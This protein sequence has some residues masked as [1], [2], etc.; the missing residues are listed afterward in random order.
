MSVSKLKSGR[1]RAQVFNR[2]TGERPSKTFETKKEALLWEANWYATHKGEMIDFQ[3]A[4][5]KYVDARRNVLSPSTLRNYDSYV[6]YY[7]KFNTVPVDNITEYMLQTWVNSL[8]D[9]I[10]PKTV[11][12]VYAHALS[13]IR[14]ELP[15]F[16]PKVLLPTIYPSNLY[17]PSE[18]EIRALVDK[19]AGTPWEVPVALAMCGLR[20]GEICALEMKNVHDGYVYIERDMVRSKNEWVIKYPK[21]ATSVRRVPVP[22][23]VTDMIKEKGVVCEL[24]PNTISDKFPDLLE[25][26]GIHR[27]RFHDLRAYFASAQ[28]ALGIPELF[29]MR[30]GGWSNTQTMRKIYTRS[31]Q[32]AEASAEEKWLQYLSGINRKETAT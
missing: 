24:T 15:L 18:E 29:T 16:A 31:I 27:F 30:S 21:T 17:M 20:R 28:H 13:V 26:I 23:A 10:A 22:K 7:T 1:W 5:K 14:T 4:Q 11:K 12:N 2:R 19:I 3:S 6:Q 32:E 9:H 25:R 8:A